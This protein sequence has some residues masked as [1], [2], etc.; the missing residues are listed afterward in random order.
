M[1]TFLKIGDKIKIMTGEQKGLIGII[2]SINIK[3]F[4]ATIDTIT[5]RIKY[6]KNPQ[7]GESKK[8]ELPIYI[9]LSNLMLWDKDTNN[10]GRVGYKVVNG[11]KKRYFKKSGNLI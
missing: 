2:Q 11:E 8:I 10:S 7:G 9:N 3:K 1:K 5:P 6:T 4:A